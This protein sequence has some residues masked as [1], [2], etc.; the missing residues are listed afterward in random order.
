MAQELSE[1][2]R[3]RLLNIQRNEDFLR[4]IGIDQLRQNEPKNEKKKRVKSDH[5][6][7]DYDHDAD[8]DNPNEQRVHRRKVPGITPA[9]VPTRRSTRGA[10][11]GGS[12]GAP[13]PLLLYQPLDHRERD[14]GE[15][16]YNDK[17]F[18]VKS[19]EH[20][21]TDDALERNNVTGPSLFEF[22]MAE[23]PAHAVLISNKVRTS[24]LT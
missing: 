5:E 1:Y 11:M 20:Y 19:E 23:N 9:N 3:V 22:I 18:Q 7:S 17:E 15:K 21:V 4:S 10:V 2:E 16:D 8:D 14:S 6:D 12:D 24:S 13:I